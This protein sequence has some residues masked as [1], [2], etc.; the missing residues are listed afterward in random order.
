[1]AAETIKEFLVGIKYD[2]DQASLQSFRRTLGSLGKEIAEFGASAGVGL[3]GFILALNKTADALAK[4]YYQAQLAQTLGSRMMQLKYAGDQVNNLGDALTNMATAIQS[5]LRSVPPYLGYLNALGVSG[6]TAKDSVQDLYEIVRQ[7]HEII[8]KNG[9][10][11]QERALLKQAGLDPDTIYLLAKNWNAFSKS[12]QTFPGLAKTSGIGNIN[13]ALQKGVEYQREWNQLWEL[14]TLSWFNFASK[15]MPDVQKIFATLITILHNHEGEIQSF[16]HSLEKYLEDLDKNGAIDDFGKSFENAITAVENLNK[17]LGSFMSNV[18]TMLPVIGGIVGL[19]TGGLA[20][21]ALGTAFGFALSGLGQSDT[22][23]QRQM[24]ALPFDKNH[25]GLGDLPHTKGGIW[26]WLKGMFSPAS[27]SSY[28][29]GVGG[30]RYIPAAYQTG[31]G[32]GGVEISSEV[33]LGQRLY[34]W[35][36]GMASYVPWVR[37]L[38]DNQDKDLLSETMSTIQGLT[39]EPGAPSTNTPTDPEKQKQMLEA[40]KFF[41]SKGLTPDQAAGV[42]ARLARES[43][44]NWLNPNAVNPISGAYGIA[45]WTGGRKGAALQTGGDLQKQLALVWQELSTSE[46]KALMQILSS[47]D[48]ASAAMAMEQFERAGNPAFSANA[49]EYARALARMMKQAS[50]KMS[51]VVSP[52]LNPGYLQTKLTNPQPAGIAPL[53]ASGGTNVN[54]S[55]TTTIHVYGGG[56]EIGSYVFSAQRRLNGDLVRNLETASI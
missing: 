17:E 47:M 6:K 5:Q 21:G 37:V 15:F 10:Q 44:G 53:S 33:G 2:Q 11:V 43:G 23:T 51:S 19:M 50:G 41:V 55:P 22:E 42:V 31:G 28:T 16:F 4:V 40:I 18:R 54:L 30:A 9:S 49:A 52:S 35:L 38:S 26:E 32:N 13:E 1:M 12:F 25:S 24:N 36:Q 48:P 3:A 20:G 45:Q 46:S 14:F 39:G 27:P 29:P 34:N 7:Y 8:E 56:P